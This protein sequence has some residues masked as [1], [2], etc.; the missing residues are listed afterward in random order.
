MKVEAIKTLKD[1][2]RYV[3]GVLNDYEGGIITKDEAMGYLGEYTG[4]LTELFW[5]NAI[6]KIK[7]DPSLLD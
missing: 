4:R 7:K 3:E 1:A 5:E 6:K 2:N